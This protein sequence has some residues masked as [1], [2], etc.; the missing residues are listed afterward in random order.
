[1]NYRLSV[2]AAVAVIL[3]SL[4]LSSVIKG[5]N[6]FVTGLGAVAVV[7]VAGILTRR[8]RMASAIT[9]TVAV[10]VAV[11]PLLSRSSWTDRVVGLV[12]VVV[13]AL[14]ATGARPLRG[15][16]VLAGY[17]AFLLLY[18]DLVFAHS[19]SF[20]QLIPS[21]SSLS[22]LGR[23]W[24]SAFGDFKYAPPVIDYAAVSLVAAAGIGAVAIAV[25]ILAVRLRRP[26]VA[27][28]PLLLLFSVPVASNLKVFGVPQMLIFAVSLAG[29]LG[30]LS[31]DGRERL[32]MWGRLVTFR[33]VQSPDETGSGPDTRELT[34]S[35]RRIGLA[36]VCL[37]IVIPVIVPTMH[38]RHLFS[39]TPGGTAGG[40]ATSGVSPLLT[41]GPLLERKPKPVLTYTTTAA[42]PSQQYFEVYALNYN[43]RRNEWLQLHSAIRPVAGAPTAA[44]LPWPAPGLVAANPLLS[45]TRTNVHISR[46]YSGPSV[47]PIPYAPTQ[48]DLGG[49]KAG[50]Y[51]SSDSLMV[52][53]SQGGEHNQPAR[54]AKHPGTVRVLR[55]TRPGPAA[56]DRQGADGGRD[57]SAAGCAGPG[58]L[59][60]E[61][62]QLQPPAGP[63]HHP[64]ATDVP[65]HRPARLLQPVR[66]GT[67][68][69][70]A[71]RW[72][73]VPDRS[74]LHRRRS[75][76]W[77]GRHLAG[78]HRRRAC[79]ARA[80][81]HR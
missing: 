16:G 81:L 69:T 30:L 51:E 71:A 63:S 55:R 27:G 3:A 50:W 31:A 78:H 11:V 14:S 8:S 15:F 54:A 21:Y 38:A 23:L 79:L 61:R 73:P 4:S 12:I 49:D 45:S 40:S 72:H 29:Y 47:L 66:V 7:A 80:L 44:R 32:R 1:M 39:T 48:L 77:V 42:D 46:D 36:A 13:T 25:D 57:D 53:K 5:A 43:A 9:A 70:G 28:L 56:R 59:V 20:G 26:A 22:E 68:G 10:L 18:L 41:V 33:H 2:T 6:W 60:P 17:L 19:S 65:H 62:L 75:G 67:C 52:F 74:G 24:R 37:A 58:G 76:T 64:L 35:G 34:A